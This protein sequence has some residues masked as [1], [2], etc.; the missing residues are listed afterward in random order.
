M[1][2]WLIVLLS[3]I[4]TIAALAVLGALASRHSTERRRR[5][6]LARAISQLLDMVASHTPPGTTGAVVIVART[7]D[8]GIDVQLYVHADHPAAKAAGPERT[9]HDILLS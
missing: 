6:T 4:G 8:N 5:N 3:V 2:T 9:F 1:N 7:P